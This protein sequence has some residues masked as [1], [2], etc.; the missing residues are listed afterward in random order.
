MAEA[1][2][3]R[4]TP[5]L[6]AKGR[7]AT[8]WGTPD[9]RDASAYPSRSASR[10]QWAWEFLRRRE[11]YR[12]RWIALVQPFLDS[13]NGFNH[14]AV[15]RHNAATLKRGVR[16][17][18]P[19]DA[20]RD[21]FKVSGNPTVDATRHNITLDP[22]RDL[23]PWFDGLGV[24][25]VHRWPTQP[26]KIQFEIDTTLPVEPQL[27]QVR[28]L[29]YRHRKR[30]GMQCDKFPR[31]LRLLDFDAAHTPDK[32]IGNHLFPGVS[33]EKLHDAIRKSSE[34]AHR[35]QTDYLLIALT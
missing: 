14:V 28:Q 33:G 32:E 23:P 8:S 3:N 2:K 4:G 9:P 6:S 7:H 1:D 22:R 16:W 34:A 21:E 5:P 26:G 12:S 35:H 15:R 31:Y 24:T 11:D 13:S 25:T 17:V 18:A 27:E 10:E 30:R 29:L 20:L 19:W